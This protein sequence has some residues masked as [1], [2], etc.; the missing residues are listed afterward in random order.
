MNWSA[1][2]LLR[3]LGRVSGIS[4][5][6]IM[7]SLVAAPSAFG[8]PITFA[9]FTEQYGTNDFVF[10]SH[11]GTP[12]HNNGTNEATLVVTSPVRFAFFN[13]QS[14]VLGTMDAILSLTAGTAAN[15]QSQSVFGTTYVRQPGLAGNFSIRRT[16]DN[17]L[18]LGGTFENAAID[19][20]L[21]GTSAMLQMSTP[22]LSNVVFSSDFLSFNGSAERSIAFGLSSVNPSVAI[23]SDGQ[24]RNFRA[25]GVGTFSADVDTLQHDAVP[26]PD[27][28][29]GLLSGLGLIGAVR[30]IRGRRSV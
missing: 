28:V 21:Q 27:T 3:R 24:L 9:Q 19:G 4:K 15:A 29:A 5:A 2:S 1:A 10:N 7:A 23:G 26:E 12:G 20:F 14:A 22:A 18:L 13:V 8:A 6:F 11:S 16:S 17:A 25:A 30:L